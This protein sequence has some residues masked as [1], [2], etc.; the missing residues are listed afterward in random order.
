MAIYMQGPPWV[1]PESLQGCCFLFCFVLFFV[2]CVFFGMRA[3]FVLDANCLFP[4]CVQALIP[5][6]AGVLLYGLQVFQ[7]NGN[8]GWGL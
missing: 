7:G 5:L 3:A 4:Q 8:N 6:I 2:F 1:A